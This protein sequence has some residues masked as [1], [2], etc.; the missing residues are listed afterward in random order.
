MHKT[1]GLRL[2]LHAV[3]DDT[4]RLQY[5]PRVRQWLQFVRQHNLPFEQDGD[6]DLAPS[7][8]L[9]W[10]CFQEELQFSWCSNTWNGILAIFPELG[11]HMPVSYRAYKAWE[12]RHIAGEGEGIPEEAVMLIAD[13]FRRS[14]NSEAVLITETSMDV[15]FRIS[16]WA[17]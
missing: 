6:A 11:H 2:V 4:M 9:D 12:R 8:L 17:H 15:Y 14:G 10:G 5:M 1:S 16:E 7:R 13:N 3:Q